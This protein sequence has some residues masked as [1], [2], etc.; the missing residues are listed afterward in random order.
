MRIGPCPIW[1]GETVPCDYPSPSPLG[2]SSDSAISHRASS[3]GSSTGSA[4]L[5]IRSCVSPKTGSASRGVPPCSLNLPTKGRPMSNPPLTDPRAN[6]RIN[7]AMAQTGG[8]G[9]PAELSGQSPGERETRPRLQLPPPWC[10][11]PVSPR[12]HLAVIRSANED[13]RNHGVPPIGRN[14]G[15]GNELA[16]VAT[17]HKPLATLGR[18][19]YSLSYRPL[20]RA[21]TLA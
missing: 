17:E 18:A 4:A 2:R 9:P 14:G 11:R 15:D 6:R 13:V 10:E 5:T 8:I 16:D 12:P 21:P 1:V 19:P 20:R 3:S 7:K